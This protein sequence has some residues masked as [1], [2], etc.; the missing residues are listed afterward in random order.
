MHW[1]EIV[2]I[3]FLVLASLFSLWAIFRKKKEKDCC[4]VDAG[5]SLAEEYFAKYGKRK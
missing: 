5:K 3:L 2:A 1:T 4:S